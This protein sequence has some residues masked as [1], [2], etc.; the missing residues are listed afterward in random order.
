MRSHQA[1]RTTTTTATTTTTTTDQPTDVVDSSIPHP[2]CRRMTSRASVLPMPVVP[3]QHLGKKKHHNRV[4]SARASH[5]HTESTPQPR[6]YHFTGTAAAAAVRCTS[7]ENIMH[8]G[9]AVSA[10]FCR[11]FSHEHACPNAR[12]NYTHTHTHNAVHAWCKPICI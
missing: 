6:E 11:S 10:L 7:F 2:R 9:L 5:A 12:A 1:V 4:S 8:A 3:L